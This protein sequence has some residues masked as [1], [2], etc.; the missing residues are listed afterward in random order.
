MV[1]LLGLEVIV[2]TGLKLSDFKAWEV[3]EGVCWIGLT[4][5]IKRREIGVNLAAMNSKGKNKSSVAEDH[6]K[7]GRV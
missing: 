6:T 5:L 4:F 7:Y 3:E 2:W 1:K